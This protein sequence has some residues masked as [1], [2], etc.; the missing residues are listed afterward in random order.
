MHG[1]GDDH[2]TTKATHCPPNDN[3]R[4]KE[5]EAAVDIDNYEEEELAAELLSICWNSTTTMMG[6]LPSL[7][8][9]CHP[10][11]HC[12]FPC[13]RQDDQTAGMKDTVACTYVPAKV[14]N[15]NVA[16]A[17][18][19]SSTMTNAIGFVAWQQRGHDSIIVT[20]TW[21]CPLSAGG[22]LFEAGQQ[23]AS[24][25]VMAVSVTATTNFVVSIVHPTMA[26][27]TTL[28]NFYGPHGL[29]AESCNNVL[30]VSTMTSTTKI[31][32]TGT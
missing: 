29:A 4:V 27:S 25:E 21:C 15:G 17:T 24:T 31:N 3:I 16:Q 23:V 28:L 10:L 8:T 19:R 18:A 7:L 2:K 32:I 20:S 5:K 13:S 6:A 22:T 12:E 11:L 14:V 30:V 9:G 1:G 26:G